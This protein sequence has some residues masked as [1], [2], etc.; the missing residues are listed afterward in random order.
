MF[1]AFVVGEYGISFVA[2]NVTWKGVGFMSGAEQEQQL[3]P[4][5]AEAIRKEEVVEIYAALLD[6]I[7]KRAGTILGMVTIRAIL[8]RAIRL[9][10]QKYPFLG[11]LTMGA[12]GLN[13]RDLHAWVDDQEKDIICQGFE[14]LSLN[15]FNL[16][17]ELTGQATVEK[18]FAD[19]VPPAG[20]RSKGGAM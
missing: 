14:E 3:T 4:E 8:R 16:L 19:E 9:T 12:E 5:Q 18:L 17:A 6:K 7:W 2:D 1:G 15:V 13:I 20:H 10:A 11:Q